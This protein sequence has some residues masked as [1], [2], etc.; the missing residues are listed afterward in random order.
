VPKKQWE[1]IWPLLTKCIFC[2]S[3]L[4]AGKQPACT[5]VCPVKAIV[6]GKRKDLLKE[7]ERRIKAAPGRYVDH[8]YGLHEVGGTGFFYISDVPFENLGFPANLP[9]TDLP[10]KTFAVISKIPGKIVGGVVLLM[11]AKEFTH[12]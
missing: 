12:E 4:E 8:I 5:E 3:R 10:S 1:E 6:F 11:A 2:N 9:T 7:A